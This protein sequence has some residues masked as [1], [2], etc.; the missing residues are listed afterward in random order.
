M[1]PKFLYRTARNV[2]FRS[3]PYFAHLAFTHR[4][5]LRCRFCHIQEEKMEELDAAG[6]KR[7]IDR[8]DHLGI[9]VLSICGGGEP[10]LRNDFAELLNYATAKGMYTKI[11]SNGTLSTAKYRELLASGV[12]EI[13]I[14]LDGVDG[15]DLP[16]SHVG[17]KDSGHPAI[18]ERLPSGGQATDHQ[19]HRLLC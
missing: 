13:A 6:M 18:L 19:P 15:D 2:V 11:T 3:R 16:Y 14:S 17:A 1:S 7:I 10:L 5:N 4:C 12:S 8:L 9:A